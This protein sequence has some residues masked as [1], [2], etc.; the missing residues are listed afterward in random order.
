MTTLVYVECSNTADA[1]N[2]VAALIDAS[3]PIEELRVRARIGE[4]WQD[5]PVRQRRPT[6]TGALVGALL[7]L[8]VGATVGVSAGFGPGESTIVPLLR[9]GALGVLVGALFG[10]VA[11]FAQWRTRADYPQGL[12]RNAPIVVGVQVEKERAAE[13]ERALRR[14]THQQ[15][16]VAD[17]LQSLPT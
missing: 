15:T 7:G 13:A 4:E 3:F 17:G 9:W 14:G 16:H 5:V 1:D 10:G 2:A 11:G 6:A 12:P 8:L